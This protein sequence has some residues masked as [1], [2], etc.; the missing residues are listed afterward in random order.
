MTRTETHDDGT[1]V[2][3]LTKL[4]V[5]KRS[6]KRE[7]TISVI[8]WWLSASRNAKNWFSFLGFSA[9]VNRS[10]PSTTNLIASNCDAKWKFIDNIGGSGSLKERKKTLD[11]GWSAWRCMSET[12]FITGE[13]RFFM[14]I[15]RVK[16]IDS[17]T[18]EFRARRL[19]VLVLRAFW[20]RIVGGGGWG[21][22]VV[23]FYN[24]L[25]NQRSTLC[26]HR[27]RC[28]SCT[29]TI[30]SRVVAGELT[31]IEERNPTPR[32]AFFI[33]KSLASLMFD[34]PFLLSLL[35]FRR[36]SRHGCRSGAGDLK[37]YNY[38]FT[39]HVSSSQIKGSFFHVVVGRDRRN[40][41]R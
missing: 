31:D 41:A 8:N 22:V 36:I 7:P 21:D 9:K 23:V 26:S 3:G 37:R 10:P 34:N 11:G 16:F 2:G 25:L 35:F 30:R 24:F 18:G 6:I 15:A 13:N 33:K 12:Y 40:V 4:H 20:A 17:D 5:P 27:I 1:T 29:N 14:L 38:F 39:L 32:P 28:C 19:R